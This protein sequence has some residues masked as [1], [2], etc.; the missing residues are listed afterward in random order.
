MVFG[1]LFSPSNR[2]SLLW[3]ARQ[4][5]ADEGTGELGDVTGV[6]T[7][8][9]DGYA[10]GSGAQRERA[11]RASGDACDESEAAAATDLPRTGD[12]HLEGVAQGVVIC[13]GEFGEGGVAGE[14][15]AHTGAA[16]GDG[17]Q[18]LFAAPSGA[19]DDVVVG[20]DSGVGAE[21][22]GAVL[23]GVRADLRE[24]RADGDPLSK[25]VTLVLQDLRDT[26]DDPGDLLF[27]VEV[28]ELLQGPRV[29]SAALF[30]RGHVYV[31]AHPVSE[32]P[33]EV[34]P[35]QVGRHVAS[36]EGD[37]HFLGAG[38]QEL[39]QRRQAAEP[40]RLHELDRP[41]VQD[42]RLPVN[43]YRPRERRVEAAHREHSA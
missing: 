33:E 24:N 41:Q 37:T 29:V 27:R 17:D 31:R 2:G 30:E 26:L 23:G 19:A 15:L 42:H 20:L 5:D 12:P 9:V 39:H 22:G 11:A 6:L 4:G 13:G 25:A 28:D 18:D 3:E 34:H 38:D 14:G 16:V 21:R 36:R 7:V 8:L 10:A 43:A 40:G 35:L 1:W 32:E